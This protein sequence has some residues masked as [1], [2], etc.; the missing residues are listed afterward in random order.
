MTL[1][2]VCGFQRPSGI[3]LDGAKY[4]ICGEGPE[5]GGEKR[6]DRRRRVASEMVCV[7]Q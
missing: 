5:V 6:E 2:T 1:A 3:K 7:G 4:V